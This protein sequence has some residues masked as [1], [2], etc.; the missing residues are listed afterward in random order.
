V[1]QGSA[2]SEFPN[3]LELTSHGVFYLTR[4]RDERFEFAEI[5]DDKRRKTLRG[6]RYGRGVSQAGLETIFGFHASK[7]QNRSCAYERR[8]MRCH[9]FTCK[10]FEFLGRES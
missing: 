4:G 7:I 6:L 1:F 10:L 9:K 8:I 2:R 3:S 5:D